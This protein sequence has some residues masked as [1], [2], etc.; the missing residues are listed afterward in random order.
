MYSNSC[1]FDGWLTINFYTNVLIFLFPHLD[2]KAS[3]EPYQTTNE[4]FHGLVA[5]GTSQNY[6]GNT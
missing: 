2:K 5:V 1:I 4:R 3:T 6:R